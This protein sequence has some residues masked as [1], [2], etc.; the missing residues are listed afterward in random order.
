MLKA[1]EL[2]GYFTAHAV[3]SI[4]ESESL[5]PILAAEDRKGTRSLT[6]LVAE[7]LEEAVAQ[8]ERRL[9]TNS[10]GAACLVLVY[11]GYLNLE[12]EGRMDALVIEVRQFAPAKSAFT[13]AIPYRP[14]EGGGGFT[15]HKPKL[16]KF[17]GP[18]RLIDSAL[19][20]FF[21]GVGQHE[22]G[23]EAWNDALDEGL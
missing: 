21:R 13:M 11:D 17:S 5:V 4:S 14:A 18:E 23:A 20:A 6:R 15:I 12:E 2:A 7:S 1:A 22:Q 8:G 10:D 19:D 16:L 3:W 9:E